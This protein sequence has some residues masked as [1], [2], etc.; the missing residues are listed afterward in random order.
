MQIINLIKVYYP[1]YLRKKKKKT[2]YNST[3]KTQL[4]FKMGK[5]G[6]DKE[7]VVHIYSGIL[8]NR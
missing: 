7:D 8:L 2:S 6:V 5:G 3:T 1:E 4:N